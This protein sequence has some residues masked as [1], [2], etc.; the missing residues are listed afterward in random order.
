MD[1]ANRSAIPLRRLAAKRED[2]LKLSP[3]VRTAFF[4]HINPRCRGEP[5]DDTGF[6]VLAR[7]VMAGRWR[8]LSFVD[9]S[10]FDCMRRN[11]I[12]YRIA[13]DRHFEEQ[14][15]ITPG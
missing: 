2:G 15:F 10:S 5:E 13:F 6:T 3:L 7:Q 11:G 1:R 9:L 8:Y 14:G 12:R 4:Q